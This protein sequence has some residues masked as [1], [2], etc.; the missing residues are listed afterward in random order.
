MKRL[1]VLVGPKGAGKSTIGH[2]LAAEPGVRFLRVEPLFLEVRARLGAS[3]P[4]FERLG[5][6]AVL[7]GIRDAFA[8]HD[9]VCIEST[10]ASTLF[11]SFLASLRA[12]ATVF[13][14]RVVATPEQCVERIRG[15]DRSLHI[16]VSDDEVDRI[17]AAALR[18]SLPWDAE[19]DNRGA[20]DGGSVRRTVRALLGLGDADRGA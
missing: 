9:T 19:I 12:L 16:P 6:A 10:G 4:D 18:V 13:L 11:A 20:L 7:E 8:R 3:H 2:L 1:L 15:R 14:V 17:N 5:F